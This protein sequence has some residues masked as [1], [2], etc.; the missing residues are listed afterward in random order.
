MERTDSSN[1]HHSTISDQ[2]W[3]QIIDNGKLMLNA[4]TRV[5]NFQIRG[6]N[7]NIFRI[8]KFFKSAMFILN[9]VIGFSTR[10][11]TKVYPS[12]QSSGTC[13]SYV[14]VR[15]LCERFHKVEF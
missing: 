3:K 12:F 10:I 13:T 8:E 2:H 15:C 9:H 7:C 11:P 4:L 14:M 5:L 1:V 6:M